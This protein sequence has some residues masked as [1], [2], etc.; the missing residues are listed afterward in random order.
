[1]CCDDYYTDPN[2]ANFRCEPGATPL[3]QDIGIACSVNSDCDSNLCLK[4]D[5]KAACSRSC[6][7]GA[8]NG[9]PTADEDTNEDGIAD[10][11][12]TCRLING[13]GY[14]W[15]DKGPL[16]PS[17]G[18]CAT[19]PDHPACDICAYNPSAPSCNPNSGVNEPKGCQSAAVNRWGLTAM[20]LAAMVLVSLRRR[21]RV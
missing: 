6:R 10:G 12:S 20:W 8:G 19:D 1:M 17:A 15:P 2:P 3:Q 11:G 9:C 18:R 14:C 7:L 4:Y 13:A 21:D 5:G 16:A